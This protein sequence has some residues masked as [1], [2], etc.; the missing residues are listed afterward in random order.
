M[1]IVFALERQSG[2]H[3]STLIC[4]R[5]LG[6]GCLVPSIAELGVQPPADDT[7]QTRE[8]F[9]SPTGIA[10]HNLRPQSRVFFMLIGHIASGASSS[11]AVGGIQRSGQPIDLGHRPGAEAVSA[12]VR[13]L[14]E[15][16]PDDAFM[17]SRL[18]RSRDTYVS[19]ASRPASS[20]LASVASTSSAVTRSQTKIARQEPCHMPRLHTLG[21]DTCADAFSHL[22]VGAFSMLCRVAPWGRVNPSHERHDPS[23]YLVTFPRLAPSA[24][25]R[26]HGFSPNMP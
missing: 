23:A 11:A 13:E 5:T 1:H 7:S 3:R 20:R 16:G 4:G 8:P 14:Q 25:Y 26:T 21:T 10:L 22:R 12:G 6:T 15:F 2:R 24:M 17:P 9:R 18:A 19:K